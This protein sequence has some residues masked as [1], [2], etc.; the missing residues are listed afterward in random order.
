MVGVRTSRG[1]KACRRKKRGCDMSRPTCGQCQKIGAKCAYE[2]RSFTFVAPQQHA[3]CRPL[4][5]ATSNQTSFLLTDRRQQLETTFWEA[6]LPSSESPYDTAFTR[7]VVATW[8]PTVRYLATM[9][10]TTRL[11]LDSCI[12]MALGRMQVDPD[13]VRHG[14]AMY[15]RALAETNQALQLSAT[16]Q[17]DA[18]LATCALLAMCEKYRPHCGPD[19]SSQATD[20]QSHVEGTARLLELRG[21]QKHVS[22]HGFALFAHARP[23]IALAGITRRHRAPLCSQQWLQ[24][25]WS[26][27]RRKRTLKDKLVD[28]TLAAAGA[29]EQL[30]Q[31]YNGS[32][33]DDQRSDKAVQ[34]CAAPIQ[35]LRAWEIEALRLHSDGS[36]NLPDVCADH[37]FGFYHLIMQFWA[38]S[39]LISARC[40]PF[41]DRYI[42]RSDASTGRPPASQALASLVPDPQK[43]A[44]NI[45]THAHHYF[46]STTGLVGPQHASFPLGAA[47]HYFAAIGQK[48]DITRDAAVGDETASST[49]RAI[50]GL[51]GLFRNDERAKS[52]GEFL[53]SMAP[54]PAPAKLKGDTNDIR[55]HERMA[56]EWFKL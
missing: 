51:Q 27:Q 50:Q 44:I 40:R 37:G 16:A 5:P 31:C 2:D 24:V 18:M 1:C 30:D 42:E 39:L 41:I 15:C 14:V 52:T 32:K 49:V 38:V 9:D 36:S 12:L 29:L 43:C 54:D 21:C 28:V 33:T 35:W 20:Y 46:S 19:V 3:A 4:S 55:Q 48:A 17:T 26:G 11:A 56:K 10:R 7:T 47:L 6:Y 23:S 25:P 34:A 13:S 8:I 22:E 53:R 45:A